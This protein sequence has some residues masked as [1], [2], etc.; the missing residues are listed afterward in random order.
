MME[1]IKKDL[2]ELSKGL[3]EIKQA[4]LGNPLLQDGGMI[5]K[6]NTHEARIGKVEAKLNYA[7]YFL[8]GVGFV[9]GTAGA[10]LIKYIV[11]LI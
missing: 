8:I 3:T 9:S 7:R 4:L 6:L 5:G 2:D 1:S 10:I 11:K